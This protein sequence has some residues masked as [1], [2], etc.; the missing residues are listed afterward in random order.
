MRELSTLVAEAASASTPAARR[1]RAFGEIVTQL[2]DMAVGYAYARLGDFHLAEDAAQH[3]FVEAWRNVGQLRD[4]SAFA[5]WLRRLVVGA[6]SRLTRGKQVQTVPIDRAGDVP[7]DEPTPHENAERRERRA[8][9]LAELRRLPEGE[10]VTTT[11]YYIGGYTQAEVAQFLDVPLGT[12]KYRLHSARKR[13]KE[14]LMD[15]VRDTLHDGAPS[16]DAAFATRVARLTQPETMKTPRYQ[17]GVEPVDGGDAWAIM[18]AC[19]AGDIETVRQFLA[20]DPALA[21]AQYW[22]QFPIHFAVREGH[23]DIARLLLEAGAEPGRSRYMYNSWRDLVREATRR[24][25]E[26][27]RRVLHDVLTTRYN[28]DPAFEELAQAI[29]DRD[30]AAVD[31][32]VTGTPELAQASDALG[33]SALHWAGLTH[34]PELIDAFLDRG[35][36]IDRPRADGQTPAM[37]AMNGDY[38]YRRHRDLPAHVTQDCWP[39]V[40]HLLERGAEYNLSIA[41]MKADATRVSAVLGETPEKARTLDSARVSYLCYCACVERTDI[42]E[43]LL[44]LGAD[45]NAPEALANRGR[46]LH[47]ACGRADVEMVELLLAHGADPNAEV[48][49]SGT[50]QH[51]VTAHDRGGPRREHVLRILR[52]HGAV[53]APYDMTTEELRDALASDDERVENEVFVSQVFARDDPDLLRALL[54]TRRDAI[55]P[56]PNVGARFPQSRGSL[57][58]LFEHGIDPNLGDWFGKTWLHCIAE[59][60]HVS[61]AEAIIGHGADVNAIE[62]EYRR[63]PLAEAAKA[64]RL[65]MAR[66]LLDHGADPNLPEDAWARP[67]AWALDAGHGDVVALLRERGGLT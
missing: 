3:A 46:A 50:C 39:T 60:G 16:R 14:G 22:Y 63:T 49:S 17:Y 52:E 32:I 26:D 61:L 44:Q 11:L 45:P 7:S 67:L 37:L 41:T 51:I 6:C 57:D 59:G 58:M 23:A 15:M 24:G 31:A 27:V 38:H 42:A 56:L 64:G 10:R 21:N 54:S 47:E 65:A 40:D 62:A 12:V 13:L 43:L 55:R 33:Q 9:V 29:R 66:V 18:K 35:A 34:Q 8:H 36:P 19:A 30:R 25:Y 4:H 1:S 48:D 2:Q 28:Y 53:P 5:A 20:G